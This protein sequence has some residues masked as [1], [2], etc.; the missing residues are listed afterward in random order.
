MGAVLGRQDTQDVA[1]KVGAVDQHVCQAEEDEYYPKDELEAD[2]H[3]LYRLVRRT[4]LVAQRNLDSAA[5]L[6]RSDA[7]A[8][9][10]DVLATGQV[11]DGSFDNRRA[12][13]GDVAQFAAQTRSDEPDQASDDGRDDEENT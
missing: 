3:C 4:E 5:K 9:H 10:V 12:L 13:G 7:L 8:A 1:K 11:V 6:A 2:A